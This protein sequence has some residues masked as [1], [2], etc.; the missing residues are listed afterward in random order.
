[1]PKELMAKIR[2]TIQMDE[3]LKI[4]GA[5]YLSPGLSLNVAT[6]LF[7]KRRVQGG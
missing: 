2:A 3:K 6:S 7:V 1:M 4:E 5:D